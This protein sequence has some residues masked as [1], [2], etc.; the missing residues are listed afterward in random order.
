MTEYTA[1]TSEGVVI[2]ALMNDIKLILELKELKPDMFTRPAYKVL[3]LITRKLFKDGSTEI[4]ILDIYAF[5]ESSKK[6]YK[7]IEDEGGVDFLDTLYSMGEGYTLDMLRPHVDNICR[8]A[9]RNEVSDMIIS[10]KDYISK[11]EDNSIRDIFDEIETR[12]LLLKGKYSTGH[13]M[14]LLGDKLDNVLKEID[15][16]S[17]K[18]FCGFPTG[19]PLV[20]KFFTYEKGE[21]VVLA[22]PAKFGKSQFVTD[23]VYRLC[24]K[25]KVPMSVVDS[26]LSDKLFTLRLI[27][28]IMN[29]NFSFIK[30]GKYKEYDWA[31]KKFEEAADLIKNSPLIHQYIS[32]WTNEEVYSEIK[33]TTIQNNIQIV[34]WD[35]LKVDDLGDNKKENVE[36][37]KMT[38]FLKNKIAGELNIAV[39]AMA[40]TSDYSKQ[41]GELRLWGS[42]QI[43]QFASTIAYFVKKNKEQVVRDLNAELGG[44]TYLFV[45]ENRNGPSMNDED[46]GVN[47]CVN[48][49]KAIFEQADQQCQEI[50]DILASYDEAKDQ[51]FGNE[52]SNDLLCL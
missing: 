42:N 4:E 19:F 50:Q 23:A 44:D 1:V 33:R 5:L 37:A 51:W 46:Y 11:S 7:I 14:G 25:N 29:V 28:R 17:H 31:V 21:L 38:N 45:K 34:F 43:K 10:L 49:A 39:V 13:K 30:T 48:K 52:K 2:G 24:I 15:K 16:N 35:Y 27:A 32:G 12:L 18:E 20:D 41:E 9:C 26:E 47:F 22:A 8:C 3:Y 36:L 6:Y 40:Q